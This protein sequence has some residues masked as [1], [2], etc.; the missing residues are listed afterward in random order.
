MYGLLGG[1][2]SSII[3]LGRF[4][5]DCPPVFVIITWFTRPFIGS[6]LAVL[7]Y[8][9][10]TSGIFTLSR[11]FGQHM[12]LC[13]LVGALAGLAEGWIFFKRG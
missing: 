11:S 12:A 1:C 4:R 8:T 3:T 10:L 6:L 2:V 9:L 5:A 13:L 7:S